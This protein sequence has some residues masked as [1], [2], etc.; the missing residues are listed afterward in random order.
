MNYLPLLDPLKENLDALYGEKGHF[1]LNEIVRICSN[2]KANKV[3]FEYLDGPMLIAYPDNIRND[4][5]PTL[6]SLQEVIRD[7]LPNSF[8]A[9]HL[10]PFYPS[11]SDFGFAPIN[12]LE[13]EPRFGQWNDIKHFSRT[14]RVMA[15]L[16]LHHT[17]A[18][19][20]WF[21][22]FLHDDP[23]Y[24]DFYFVT[25]NPSDYSNVMKGR[26][27]GMLTPFESKTG[28]KNLFTRFG[29]DQ[30]D[31]NYR[32]PN[33][34]IELIRVIVEI[35]NHGIS[36][37]R[38]DAIA[39]LWKEPLSS[40]VH[41]EQTTRI[42]SIL[43]IVAAIINPKIVVIP[44]IDI[45][46]YGKLYLKDNIDTPIA[47]YSFAFAPIL[48][49]ACLSGDV[50]K[51]ANY[52]EIDSNN[53]NETQKIRFLAT[54]DGLFLLPYAPVL[55][56]DETQQLSHATRDAGGLVAHRPSDNLIYE[57][58]VP[59][60]DLLRNGSPFGEDRAAAC[61]FTLLSVQ[62]IP[63]IFLNQLIA[64]PPDYQGIIKYGDPRAIVRGSLSSK[65]VGD[66][67]SL[68]KPHVA[69]WLNMLKIRRSEPALKA[70][71][72]MQIIY[73]Q[74]GLL[75]IMRKINNRKLIALVN[76]GIKTVTTPEIFK[77]FSLLSKV[78]VS[79]SA[80]SPCQFD[81]ILIDS[82]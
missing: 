30:I 15:D 54:H 58:N 26:R 62:G 53:G 81:W 46:Y 8:Q 42:L 74:G 24:R 50:K 20:P 17:S 37:I 75:I 55:S 73:A 13:V 47:G 44:E 69:R 56:E 7:W 25:E 32:N 72:H 36:I 63:A 6:F 35:I 33:V 38:L 10:L 5:E 48:I 82:I 66:L 31:L 11:T 41:L 43:R 61:L 65:E 51:L 23:Y 76:F 29:A 77:G 67:I 45:E 59:I 57:L 22:K 19:H 28:F 3:S 39:Y 80:L 21:Q 12:Y 71:S 16:I 40:C 60:L 64:T 27:L 70:N 79:I 52:L 1:I 2:N 78:N 18:K 14:G 49:S 9:L 4:D 34:L 68:R